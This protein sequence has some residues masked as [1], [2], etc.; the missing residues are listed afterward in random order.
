MTGLI[1]SLSLLMASL[2]VSNVVDETSAKAAAQDY[3]T[4]VLRVVQI[5][6]SEWKGGKIVYPANMPYQLVVGTGP[7]DRVQAEAALQT[8]VT[9]L[10]VQVRKRLEDCKGLAFVQQWLIR[11]CR[12]G[13]T[14]ESDYLSA[15]AHPAVWT[16]KDFELKRLAQQSALLNDLPMVPLIRPLYEEYKP[17]PIRRAEPL[18]EYPDPRPETVFETSYGVAIVL[19]APECRRKFRF[20]AS[21]WP[22]NDW[23]V[24][25]KWVVM[26]DRRVSIGRIQGRPDLSPGRGRAEL[27]LDWT[28]IRGRVDVAVFARYGEGPWGPPSVISF[29]AVP[30]ER[31]KYGKDGKIESIEYLD[32][33]VVF[34]QLYQ[35]KAWSDEYQRDSLGNVIGFLRYKKDGGFRGEPF[36]V[37][38]ESVVESYPDESPKVAAKVRYFT[39]PDGALDY[40][41]TTDQVTYKQRPFKPIDRGEFPIGKP[42]RI[43]RPARK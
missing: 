38:G 36:S 31:R 40:E 6:D 34:P 39:R 16:A 4:N 28:N 37:R 42:G 9:S 11:R 13:V 22:V 20:A 15:K 29:Y 24:N 7:E 8:V 5:D 32:T 19:R 27:V 30:N 23:R 25:Y 33:D 43:A 21:G 17:A 41:I 26:P 10:Q 35:N 1:A 3:G 14:N 18:V 2:A 12:P